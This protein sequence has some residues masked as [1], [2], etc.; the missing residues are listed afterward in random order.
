MV[1][2][3]TSSNLESTESSTD[4]RRHSCVDINECDNFNTHCP[5]SCT[6]LKG[7]YQCNCAEN[8]YDVHGDGSICEVSWS[9]DSIILI[10]YGSEIRQLRQ[11]YSN[12]A[13]TTLIEDENLVIAM[14][15]DPVDRIVYWIDESL[16]QI[17]RSFI[18]VSKTAL[19]HPQLLSA[20]DVSSSS[21]FNFLDLTAISIDWLGKN[22]YYA[23]GVNGTIKV[24]KS[25]GRYAK[26][27]IKDFTERIYS[28]VVNPIIG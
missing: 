26:T 20:L 12:L 16:Q 17:K 22:L 5:Q 10:A 25:D 2:I 23:E 7:S 28:M 8:Y 18:P 19:G 11:N 1:K 3:N 14:D 24:T 27:I 15:I 21:S 4:I 13:Y 6:N 9:E